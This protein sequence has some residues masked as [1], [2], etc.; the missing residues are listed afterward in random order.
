[1]IYSGY[2]FKLDSES[3][4]IDKELTSNY[5]ETKLKYKDGDLFRIT[6]I[7]GETALVKLTELE[8]FVR[9]IK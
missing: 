8:K 2:I 9:G 1:M 3:I 7:A 4:V 5:L 6:T